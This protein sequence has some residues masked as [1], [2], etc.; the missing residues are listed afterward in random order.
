MKIGIIGTGSHI[1]S[2]ITK[3]ENFLDHQFMET[4]GSSFEQKNNVIIENS[5]IA[6]QVISSYSKTI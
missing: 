4:D 2:I 3:N 5:K 6:S 1:P